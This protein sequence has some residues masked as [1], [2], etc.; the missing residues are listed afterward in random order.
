MHHTSV[1]KKN[2]I[3]FLRLAWLAWIDEINNPARMRDSRV[4]WTCNGLIDVH[5]WSNAD[6]LNQQMYLV[7]P[8]TALSL[9]FNQSKWTKEAHGLKRPTLKSPTLKMPTLK[10]RT[11]PCRLHTF[12]SIFHV[13]WEK[14]PLHRRTHLPYVKFLGKPK[15]RHKSQLVRKNRNELLSLSL[16]T[17]TKRIVIVYRKKTNNTIP[18]N[19]CSA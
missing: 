2:W 10:R 16:S 9:E 17:E 19:D 3:I 18:V 12:E 1:A 6:Q 11:M 8:S 13:L 14:T 7:A 15:R 4:N 5:H